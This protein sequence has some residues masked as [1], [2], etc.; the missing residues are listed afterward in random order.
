M[1]FSKRMYRLQVPRPLHDDA[2]DFNTFIDRLK[3][4]QDDK[5]SLTLATVDLVLAA[6][7]AA[8]RHA[9]EAAAVPHWFDARILA[10]LGHTQE[11]VAADWVEQLRQLPFVESFAARHAWNVHEATRVV[12]RDH[13]YAAEPK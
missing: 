7:D 9:L 8:L 1:L 10:A 5:K 13:L 11:S 4:S 2:M 12:L 6:H 3:T